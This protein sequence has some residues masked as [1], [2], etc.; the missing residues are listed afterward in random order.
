[1]TPMEE[2][3]LARKGMKKVG[4]KGKKMKTTSTTLNIKKTCPSCPHS[5]PAN[6]LHPTVSTR[7]VGLLRLPDFMK[8]GECL[9]W[10]ID[11]AWLLFPSALPESASQCFTDVVRGRG[12]DGN[13]KKGSKVPPNGMGC[14]EKSLRK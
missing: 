3:V 1:M 12:E 8:H 7:T 10:L 9:K 14:P 11:R 6:D 5:H 4:D 2:T 13:H